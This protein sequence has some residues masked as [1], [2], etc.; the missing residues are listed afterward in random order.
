MPTVAE[1]K[2]LT[3]QTPQEIDEQLAEIYGRYYLAVGKADYF[4]KQM[5]W[6]RDRY[7][8]GNQDGYE[9]D[10]AKAR[11]T[12][13]AILVEAVPFRVE[14]E[15]RGG[16]TRAYLVTNA[17]GHVH[18]SMACP[19]CFPS[20]QY[21]WVTQ[22]SDHAEIEIV[23]AAGESACT[24]CYP[25]APVDVLKR[26]SSIELPERR[27][28]RLERD[29]K[30]AE[31]AA[32]ALIDPDTGLLVRSIERRFGPG[33]DATL[34]DGNEIGKTERGAELEAISGLSSL[35]WYGASHPSAAAWRATA[36]RVAKALA[37]KHGEDVAVVRARFDT[38]AAASYKR[39]LRG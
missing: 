18:S 20:T 26:K 4:F 13:D 6:H 9:Q 36:D 25:S 29:R 5:H 11:D 33:S 2:P 7:P 8:A 34:R 15:R 30:A 27:A 39:Q 24:F 23:E 35:L 12:A 37:V 22:L 16:W 3:E 14:F 28:A 17:G 1:T 19:T 21:H 38:K 31:R 32:K 10:Y